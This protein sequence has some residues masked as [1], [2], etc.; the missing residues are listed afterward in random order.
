M[1]LFVLFE[2]CIT[3]VYSCINF[4]S[5]ERDGEREEGEDGEE[6]KRPPSPVRK[7]G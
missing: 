5:K 6:R 7:F 1:Y 2:A 4:A 3:R